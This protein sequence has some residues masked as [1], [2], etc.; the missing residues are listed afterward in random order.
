MVL[1][2]V[3]CL[4]PDNRLK[5][6]NSIKQFLALRI[7]TNEKV[8]FGKTSWCN[9]WVYT[10]YHKNILLH[11]RMSFCFTYCL[12]KGNKIY[13][14]YHLYT[15]WKNNHRVC[16]RCVFKTTQVRGLLWKQL[17]YYLTSYLPR[18]LEATAQAFWLLASITRLGKNTIGVDTWEE[19]IR[20]RRW[21]SRRFP[22]GYL[23][24]TSSQSWITPW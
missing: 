2:I 1:F 5:Y 3:I 22:Y 14:L 17:E 4:S 18:E 16:Q 9:V 13:R 10:T 6:A 8:F 20:L 21:S 24:T 23:V 15:L 12:I 7:F 19:C 11:L